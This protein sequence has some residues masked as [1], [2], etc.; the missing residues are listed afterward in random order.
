MNISARRRAVLAETAVSIVIARGEGGALTHVGWLALAGLAVACFDFAQLGWWA[1]P[2]LVLFG[3][4]ALAAVFDARFL[5]IPDGPL[6]VLLLLGLAIL[7]SD[8]GEAALRLAAAAGGYGT[9]RAIDAAYRLLRGRAGLGLADAHLLGLA[10]LW[11][12]PAA[13]PGCLL[14]AVVSAFLSAL[15]A[16]RNGGLA[17]MAQPIPFGP[18]LALGFWLGWS[19]GPLEAAQSGF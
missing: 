5:I 4:L 12:G 18:H 9:L 7:P 17:Q 14:I 1:A 2:T 19:L 8:G 11:L 3:A 15:I 16:A 13:L 10:G 6:I